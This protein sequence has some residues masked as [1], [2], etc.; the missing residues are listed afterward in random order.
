M[1][2]AEQTLKEETVLALENLVKIDKTGVVCEEKQRGSNL[3]KVIQLVSG[4][5]K[6]R[7][8]VPHLP[9]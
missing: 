2:C 9:G 6:K 8:H 4:T 3:T 5:A 7:T 1:L